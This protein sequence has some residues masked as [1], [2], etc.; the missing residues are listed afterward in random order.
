MNKATLGNWLEKQ[1]K[2]L[3][4]TPYVAVLTTLLTEISPEAG[5]VVEAS[6]IRIGVEINHLPP[7]S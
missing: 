6:K 7:V 3:L 1:G 4:A 5:D 2:G